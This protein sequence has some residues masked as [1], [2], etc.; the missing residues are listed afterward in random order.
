MNQ[1][2]S[3]A[4]QEQP[5]PYVYKQISEIV[6]DPTSMRS[7]AEIAGVIFIYLQL[8]YLQYIQKF[9]F[10]LTL[11]PLIFYSLTQVGVS[12]YCYYHESA[13][14][15]LA[16]KHISSIINWSTATLYGITLAIKLSVESMNCFYINICFVIA[17][18]AKMFFIRSRWTEF[19]SLGN[20]LM[21]PF[22]YC[23]IGLSITVS[24]KIDQVI[25]ISW[26]YAF[27]YLLYWI[28]INVI[29]IIIQNNISH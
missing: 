27:W 20:V 23:F 5:S 13:D 10:E 28:S 12:A 6:K 1:Q 22:R 9:S 7:V 4:I 26:T 18:I 11:I 8:L 16:L 15:D 24:L 19:T 3:D 29:N 2:Q 14:H 17:L 25:E 21:N